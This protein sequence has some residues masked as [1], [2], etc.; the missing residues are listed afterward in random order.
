MS[1]PSLR[2]VAVILLL[3]LASLLRLG[4]LKHRALDNDEIAE[5]SWSSLPFR[6]MIDRVKADVVHPP[7]DYIVQFV[8]GDRGPEWVRRLPS[9]I[10]GTASVGLIIALGAWWM[11]WRAGA[12]T[13]LLLAVSP[14][15][16]FYS[17]QVRPYSCA[18][19]YLLGSLVT[20]ELYAKTQK[21]A[22]AAAWFVLVFVA[23]ATLYFAGMVAALGSGVRIFLDRKEQ[24]RALWPRLPLVIL[25]W[26]LLYSPWFGVIFTAA[27]RPSPNPAE[28][29]DWAW[30]TWRL[31]SL[32][33]GSGRAGEAVSL[34]SWAFWFIVV[35]GVA[36]SIRVR[37]L[38]VPAIMF[39]VGSAIEVMLLQ[40]HPHYPAPRYLMPSWIAAFIL[41]GAAL[42]SFSRHWSTT[43]LAVAIAGLFVGCS[44]VR[45]D[46][47]YR[48]NH[49]DWREVAAYVHERIR[50]GE[51][52]VAANPW[53][54]RNF[55]YYWH[56]LPVVPNLKIEKYSPDGGEVIGPAW[57]VT[58]GCF[59]RDPVRAAPVMKRFPHTELAEVRLLRPGKR[60]P[61]KEEWC[62]E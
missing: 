15:H 35:A 21:R 12:F 5:V 53:V 13:G 28:K 50:P 36:I 42:D 56:G 62:P 7:A 40:I 20:L 8:I 24:L 34:A 54:V 1:L 46:D 6:E 43:P 27:N 19:F 32:A 37:T 4:Q 23:G 31:Q 25:I 26:E 18:L 44:A 33:A 57:I 14:L 58:G 38:R 55:G 51:T 16:V 41:A 10:A 49:S 48:G 60:M 17:Q 45:I 9:V 59:P 29:L 11:S 3:V 22:W 30:W 52:L 47:Y 39:L 2:R 61:K